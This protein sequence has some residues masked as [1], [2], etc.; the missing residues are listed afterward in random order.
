MKVLVKGITPRIGIK[1]TKWGRARMGFRMHM[2]A[3]LF[4]CATLLAAA[5]SAHFITQ[6]ITF[7]NTTEAPTGTQWEWD[8]GDGAKSNE[9]AHAC[10]H[11]AGRFQGDPHGQGT[12]RGAHCVRAHCRDRAGCATALDLPNGEIFVGQ[13]VALANP[14]LSWTV[15]T[16][17]KAEPIKAHAPKHRFLTSGSQ[18]VKLTVN[19][20]NGESRSVEGMLNIL[21]IEVSAELV[22]A[23][24]EIKLG[25]EVE[26]RNTSAKTPVSLSWQW[27]FTGPDGNQTSTEKDAK[28][29]FFA[30]GDYTVTLRAAA[31]SSRIAPA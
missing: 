16:L 26:F 31:G 24:E 11:Q 28:H 2:L 3:G 19:I 4:A 14:A 13:E 23:P 20:P 9:E 1:Q 7:A 21:P 5:E 12:E 15:W 17:G 27:T 30:E 25:K 18:P 8:F 10:L 22:T 29:K 6:K